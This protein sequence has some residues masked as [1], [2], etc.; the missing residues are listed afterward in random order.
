MSRLTRFGIGVIVVLAFSSAAGYGADHR[1][2]PGVLED[3]RTDIND[4]YIFQSPDNHDHTVLVLTVNPL[5]GVLSPTT[6]HPKADYIIKV[7]TDGDAEENFSLVARF[8]KPNNSGVQKV[9]LFGYPSA[10]H[11][12]GKKLAEGLTGQTV[13]FGDGGK[14]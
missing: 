10:H 13:K 11:G 3:G 12:P 1:D 2:A 6:F 8:S 14:L 4:L 9:A 5:A 7:D